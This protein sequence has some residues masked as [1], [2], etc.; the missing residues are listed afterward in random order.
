MSATLDER[1]RFAV[2]I[3]DQKRY[4]PVPEPHECDGG[5][6]FSST[7]DIPQGRLL[8]TVQ[9]KQQGR[10]FCGVAFQGEQSDE[11]HVAVE[12]D[13]EKTEESYTL[14]PGV[15]YDGNTFEET[16]AIPAINAANQWTF[17]TSVAAASNPKCLHF[18][19]ANTVTVLTGSPFTRVG[20]SGFVI[21][22]GENKSCWTLAF[23]T[24]AQEKGAYTLSQRGSKCR[25]GVVLQDGD[26]ITFELEY[27]SYP[28][29]SITEMFNLLNRRLRG[30]RGYAATSAAKMDLEIGAQLVSDW[31][32][33]AHHITDR[34]GHSILVNALTTHDGKG[35]VEAAQMPDTYTE[36][37]TGWCSGTMT[38]Y[39]LLAQGGEYRDAAIGALDFMAGESLSASGLAESI[40]D[41]R[42]WRSGS[43]EEPFWNHVRMP[44]DFT[45]YLLK[46]ASYEKDRGVSHPKWEDAARKN[47][48]AFC[49]LWDNHGQF[50][51]YVDKSASVPRITRSGSCA[52]APVCLALAVG[53]RY[54]SDN[55]R[56][57]S[58]YR[59]ASEYYFEHYVAKGHCTGGPLD[60]L[61]A[62]DSE[63]A[64]AMTD[65]LTQGALFLKDKTLIA[66]AEA[67]A[68][69]FLS[70]VVSYEA[71]FPPGSTLF[72]MNPCGG[73]IA[74]VQNR[75]IGPG[76]CTNS[77]RFLYD[78]SVLTGNSFYADLH[79]DIIHAALNFV[80]AE[81]GEFMG[82]GRDQGMGSDQYGQ[83]TPFRKGMVSE[84]INLA[85]TLNESGEMWLVSA[86]WPATF[87]LLASAE[88]P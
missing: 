57:Q 23:M 79:Q 33:K 6:R 41:G 32:L 34:Q 68:Q 3:N 71:P 64:A 15:Y 35:I 87:V 16:K 74:N 40:Y 77:G 24:P 47:L 75:H 2:Y 18:D 28:A 5:I 48:D 52:G 82:Y 76:I 39:G 62:D 19:G 26:C 80:V 67:A 29:G 46:A 7:L 38:A 51:L 55:D 13:I 88:R 43:A 61:C 56:Y 73:V 37:I 49:T 14:I 42:T 44:A 22:G 81:E 20:P 84:Q 36:Q 1:L 27:T 12:T 54:F 70:W 69:I 60:I 9:P 11:V 72:G 66:K 4:F 86:S 78:L 17:A 30:V 10:Y 63:S 65:A 50:G 31:L 59:A 58:V 8:L 53:M 85:D 25:R 45:M 83:W 21:E